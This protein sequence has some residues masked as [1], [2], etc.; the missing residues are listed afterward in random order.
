MKFTAVGD[1]LIQRRIPEGFVGIREIS[2]YIM[3]GDARF[4]N[5]ETTLN[6]EG[7]C[8]ASQFS[9]GTYV[10]TNPEALE[11][12]KLYGFNMTNFN[13]N[14]TM[15][16]SYG[17]MFRTLECL[18]ASGLVHSGVG[19]NLEA[20]S[21][22]RYLDTVNGRVALISVCTSFEPSMMAGR[23][24]RKYPGR[25]GVNGLR[26]DQVLDV[27][28]ADLKY[29]REL[30]NRLN[31]NAEEKNSRMQGYSPELP[32]DLAELGDLKFRASDTVGVKRT[33]N[34]EDMR[35]VLQ[36]ISEANFQADYTIISLH[37][38][39]TDTIREE[40]PPEFCV[41]FA[42]CCIDA[43][44][45]AVIGHGPHRLRPIEV[46]KDSPI[47]YSLGDFI[48]QLYSVESAPEDFFAQQGMT[49]DSTVYELLKKRSRGFKVGLMEKA[50]MNQSVIPLFEMSKDGKLKKLELLPI[51]LMKD[52]NKSENGLPRIAKDV[53]FMKDFADIC[54][55]YG[56]KIKPTDKGTFLCEW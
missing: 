56:V 42:H 48:L 16:F 13:N 24:S 53:S 27:S 29:I 38:H 7:E 37:T 1:A 11:D 20:A 19:E 40:L 49:S 21:A 6:R 44:A 3:K 5:L 25:P 51:T 17:G 15:D 35:R 4:F 22:P 54:M 50:V 36:S 2:E 43:G 52:G 45:N 41:D 32:E 34:G 30:E 55:Q 14:H 39:Q 28:E 31:L 23:Q 33:V 18:N 46:Y 47:F 10:R 26:I 12:L 8:C 9:G